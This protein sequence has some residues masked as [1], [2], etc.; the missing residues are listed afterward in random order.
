MAGIKNYI[1][2]RGIFLKNQSR[3]F[4]LGVL[5]MLLVFSLTAGA[6]AASQQQ[7]TLSYNDIQIKLDGAEIVPTDANGNLVEP[8]II[9]GTTY[10]PVRAI[11][12]ALDLDIAWDGETSTV[13]LTSPQSPEATYITRT[14]KKYHYDNS[15]NGGTYWEVPFSTAV[16]MG[17]EPCDKCVK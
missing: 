3:G 14:G 2:K 10:L 13:L 15:C 6:Y 17:L 9:D 16:G 8:F 12:D 11:A 1:K 7:A 5:T 4:M